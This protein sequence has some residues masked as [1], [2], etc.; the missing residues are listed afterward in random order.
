MRP[1]VRPSSP[2]KLTFKTMAKGVAASAPDLATSRTPKSI[3]FLRQISN[4][5]LVNRSSKNHV[6]RDH[7]TLRCSD[8]LQMKEDPETSAIECELLLYIDS[9]ERG[10][11]GPT[12]SPSSQSSFFVHP[13]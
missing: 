12:S 4:L 2:F 8:M 7:G 9:I 10:I 3:G 13:G 6:T 1:V 11:M 5:D